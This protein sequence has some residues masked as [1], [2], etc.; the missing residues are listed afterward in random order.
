METEKCVGVAFTEENIGDC[1][2]DIKLLSELTGLPEELIDGSS[3]DGW[4][5][6]IGFVEGS[7]VKISHDQVPLSNEESDETSN[8]R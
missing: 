7:G 6:I 5:E 2:R 1:I 3:L 8:T 4:Y